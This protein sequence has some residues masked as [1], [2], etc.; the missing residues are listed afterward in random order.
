MNA[1][2]YRA[3]EAQLLNFDVKGS[4]MNFLILSLNNDTDEVLLEWK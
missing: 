2:E 4:L 1:K 3:P